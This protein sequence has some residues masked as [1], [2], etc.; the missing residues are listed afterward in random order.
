MA[1]NKK[2]LEVVAEE[3]QLEPS[4]AELEI[5]E[6]KGEPVITFTHG[7]HR[8]RTLTVGEEVSKVGMLR[9]PTRTIILA[10]DAE[11]DGHVKMS[12]DIAGQYSSGTTSQENAK[13]IR[14][15]L[16][17]AKAQQQRMQEQITQQQQTK[18]PCK[19]CG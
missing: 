9:I 17:A 15:I 5:P 1:K 6:V 14:P 13:E 7:V 2:E 19:T 10:H 16:A 18:A 8:G 4:A 12:I 3:Q 11:L